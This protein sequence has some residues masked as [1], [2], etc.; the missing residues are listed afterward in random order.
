[1]LPGVFPNEEE[2]KLMSSRMNMVDEFQKANELQSEF[3][4]KFRPYL[5]GLT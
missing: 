4:K 5:F 2:R 3:N 1:M